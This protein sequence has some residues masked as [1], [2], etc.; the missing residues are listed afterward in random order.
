MELENEN[1]VDLAQ[2]ESKF[3]R[4]FLRQ[5]EEFKSQL[6][7]LKAETEDK[8][9]V[10]K[11]EIKEG[12]DRSLGD[13]YSRLAD[14]GEAIDRISYAIGD[15]ACK[16]DEAARKQDEAA[17]KQDEMGALLA[18]MAQH[19][20]GGEVHSASPRGPPPMPAPEPPLYSS[21][22][23]GHFRVVS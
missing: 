1:R 18:R 10:L 19:V 15:S 5:A 23:A 2:L 22:P 8:V 16:Q 20:L 3:E 11:Q 9:A 4:A 6:Q 14:Q 13:I 17:R 12:M 7:I 21:A